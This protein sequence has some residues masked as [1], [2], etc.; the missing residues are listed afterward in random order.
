VP[1]ADADDVAADDVLVPF[2][3]ADEELL[4]QALAPSTR[5]HRIPT[6]TAA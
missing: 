1:L 4:L 6:P 3:G 2:P 5:T